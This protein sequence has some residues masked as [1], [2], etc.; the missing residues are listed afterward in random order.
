MQ[1]PFREWKAQHLLDLPDEGAAHLADGVV[2]A[3]LDG[4]E[5]LQDCVELVLEQ[6]R[7]RRG[8]SQS[9]QERERAAAT[10][11]TWTCDDGLPFDSRMGMRTGAGDAVGLGVELSG[12]GGACSAA[13][14]H[15][16][17]SLPAAAGSEHGAQAPVWDGAARRLAPKTYAAHIAVQERDPTP[18]RRDCMRA[19][20]RT[21]SPRGSSLDRN[22]AA[23]QLKSNQQGLLLATLL[24]STTEVFLAACLDNLLAASTNSMLTSLLAGSQYP[25]LLAEM[26]DS[27]VLERAETAN[28]IR[29]A[30]VTLVVQRMHVACPGEIHRVGLRDEWVMRLLKDALKWVGRPDR[31]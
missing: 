6:R 7:R 18:R 24:A 9:V 25:L 23:G 8:G 10:T 26:G 22:G 12:T 11:L 17:E 29:V 16:R 13:G 20:A 4:V 2:S 14:V 21:W 5:T 30:G 19:S 3:P 31:S 27:L 15:E 28:S 1:Q